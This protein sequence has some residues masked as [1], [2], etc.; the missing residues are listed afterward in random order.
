MNG[1]RT[2]KKSRAGFK[3]DQMTSDGKFK[4]VG[5]Y[6]EGQVL[7]LTTTEDATYRLRDSTLNFTLFDLRVG[8]TAL[9]KGLSYRVLPYQSNDQEA[10]Q[11]IAED[12]A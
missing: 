12:A 8:E 2:K 10:M 9:V 4:K 6:R 1:P 7:Q 5:D 3:L 11:V